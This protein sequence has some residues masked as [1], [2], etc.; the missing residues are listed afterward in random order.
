MKTIR[1]DWPKVRQY[2]KSGN[3]YFSVD[4]RRKH[5]TGSKFK[6]FTDK[7]RALGYAAEV[8]DQ[9]A[10]K[11]LISLT[12][13]DPRIKVWSAQCA[14]FGKTLDQAFEIALGVFQREQTVKES[15][16]MAEL[17][18]VWVLD[19]IENKLKPLRPR[20]IKTIRNMADLF[21]LDFG[22]TRMKEIDQK[23][24]ESYLNGKDVSNQ[25]R[26]N[27]CNY[28]G[29]FF[30]WSML[31]NY[32]DTNPAEK[33][34]VHVE[35]GVPEFFTVLQCEELMK[36]A[37][38]VENQNMT[39]YFA[40][41][42]F[43][44]IRPDECERMTWEKNIKMDSKEIYLQAAIT[45]TKKDRLFTMSDNLYN[46]LN[47]CQENKPLVPESNIK[48]HRVKVCKGTNFEWIQDG[49]R[50][51]FATFH[52]AKFKS[53]EELRHIMGNSPSIIERFYKGTIPA[54]EVEKF[55]QI[56]PL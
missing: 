23:R 41:C 54:A 51:T 42:L 30:N 2:V 3:T 36:A 4:L 38:T 8:G 49:M 11:G 52:Y 37:A 25:T 9:V 27:I 21:K 43:A 17:L 18:S 12:T 48:N 14:V 7:D 45:K 40:L 10:Q 31:K 56:R 44:G 29:Q 46:W 50:H 15:P 33:I 13:D 22:M 16:Y 5:Y 39:A 47:F 53:L 26:K 34:E 20:T 28:L 35:N 24:V 1:K 6:N 55:W 19:K 32:H